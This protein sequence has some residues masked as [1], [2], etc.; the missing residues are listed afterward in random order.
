MPLSACGCKKFQIDSFVDHLC[1]CTSHSGDRKTHDCS[2]DQIADPFCRTN[3]V[4]TQQVARSRG[5]RCGDIELAA[6]LANAAGLV[7]L[8]LD[9]L[10]THD[11][12]GSSSVPSLNEH[13]H[14]PNDL[15][16]SLNEAAADKI[17]QNGRVP[18]T[19]QGHC[20]LV[21]ILFLQTHGKTLFA[22]SGIHG[23]Q[24]P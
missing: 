13:L 17:R 16:G 7:S 21:R 10:I 11:L 15:D 14:Y 9:L 23:V 24:S 3:K 12:F 6:Y 1:T 5:Q 2:T 18:L 8:V 19:S 22:D 20:E 4:R